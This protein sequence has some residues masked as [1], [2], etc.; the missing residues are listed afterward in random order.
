MLPARRP[1]RPQQGTWSP[2]REPFPVLRRDTSTHRSLSAPLHLLPARAT[3]PRPPPPP[4]LQPFPNRS[5]S[6]AGVLRDVREHAEAV[7]SYV[8]QSAGLAVKAGQ[9]L[10]D[11]RAQQLGVTQ[12][13]RPARQPGAPGPVIVDLHVQPGHEGGRVRR[14]KRIS[15]PLAACPQASGK[16]RRPK[17]G[18]GPRPRCPETPVPWIPRASAT[19]G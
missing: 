16:T 10:R 12:P 19:S 15:S 7:G 6:G 8:S 17:H 14:H 2:V 9:G 5:G 1:A 3:S 4:V 18:P 13:R 11:G